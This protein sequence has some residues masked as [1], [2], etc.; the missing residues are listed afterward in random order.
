MPLLQ[1]FTGNHCLSAFKAHSSAVLC[2]SDT[3]C[4][5]LCEHYKG[6]AQ[7]A[8]T[9]ASTDGDKMG[10]LTTPCIYIGALV[11]GVLQAGETGLQRKRRLCMLPEGLS[12]Y[13]GGVCRFESV[14]S[15]SRTND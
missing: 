8:L 10:D 6:E 15:V 4:L 3:S 12:V 11:G 14:P 2:R 9:T 13:C 5:S 7:E 1:Q